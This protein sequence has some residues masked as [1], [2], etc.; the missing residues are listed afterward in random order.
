M[1][2]EDYIMKRY[3]FNTPFEVLILSREKGREPYPAGMTGAGILFK[4]GV[5]KRIAIFQAR[6]YVIL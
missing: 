2:T 5:D 1:R 6:V 4:Y 3:S